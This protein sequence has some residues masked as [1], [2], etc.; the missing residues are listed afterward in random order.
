MTAF[1]LDQLATLEKPV[2]K[3]RVGKAVTGGKSEREIQREIVVGLR[4]LGMMVFHIP[5]EGALA[6]GFKH[7]AALRADGC[8]GGIPDLGIIWRAGA[9]GML[10]VKKPGGALSETQ[11]FII[12]RLQLRGVPVAVVTSLDEAV[13]ALRGWQWL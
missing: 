13:A 3:K 2:R 11:Q 10:E 9:F 6:G 4:K 12:E 1:T 8:I 5:N 7:W